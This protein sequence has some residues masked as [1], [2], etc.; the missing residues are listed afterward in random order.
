MNIKVSIVIISYN[1]GQFIERTIKSVL[2]QS[3]QNLELFLID[4]GSNDQT[5]DIVEKYKTHF[6]AIVHEKDNGQTDAINKGFRMATG[7]LAGWVNSDDILY[8]DCVEE[9]VKAYNDNQ[10]GA[11][12]YSNTIDA[13]DVSDNKVREYSNGIPNRAYLLKEDYDVNQPGSFYS[14]QALSKVG[15]LDESLNYCMDLDLWL[16]LLN[17]GVIYQGRQRVLAAIRVGDYT[18]TNTGGVHFLREIRST[19][20]KHGAAITDS[21]II[22]TYWYQFKCYIKQIINY[23][24]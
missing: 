14:T 3:Y 16:R 7:E 21:T 17:H 15:Y 23:K 11:I 5:M 4:G 8:A 10:D 24:K 6:T 18:K 2:A 19:L 22:R 1:Q 13:I 9:I 12:Y 20:L